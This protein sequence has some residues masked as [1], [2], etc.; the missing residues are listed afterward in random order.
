MIEEK[1]RV[2]KLSSDSFTSDLTDESNDQL[3][4]FVPQSLGALLNQSVD[5]LDNPSEDQSEQGESIR[6]NSKS[7]ESNSKQDNFDDI[8]DDSQEAKE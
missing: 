7:K 2:E 4:K 3:G 5:K 8:S 1:K 6:E